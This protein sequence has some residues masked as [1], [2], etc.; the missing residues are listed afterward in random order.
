[1]KKHHHFEEK[2][3]AT[4][5]QIY[6]AASGD[7]GWSA[8]LESVCEVLAAQAVD[9]SIFRAPAVADAPA[10]AAGSAQSGFMDCGAA[11]MLAGLGRPLALFAHSGGAEHFRSS[12]SDGIPV[13]VS[14]A[15]P[16]TTGAVHCQRAWVRR[17][18][19]GSP[20]MV[21]TVCF[22]HQDEVA[23]ELS[24]QRL[25][26]LLPH[27]RRAFSVEQR[28]SHALHSEAEL[29][30]TLDHVC[31]AVVL[32]NSDAQ[33]LYANELALSLLAQADGICRASDQLLRLPD[34]ASQE[35][36]QQVLGHCGQTC[37]HARGAR[38]ALQ[39][40]V[41]GQAGPYV[42]TVQPLSRT[43]RLRSD[44][45]AVLLIQVPQTAEIQHLQPMRDTYGLTT[46]ELQLVHGLVNGRSLKQIAASK[47]ASYETMRV[48]LRQVFGKTGVN[49]QAQLVNLA[50]SGYP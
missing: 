14:S 18:D 12:E 20:W 1:M 13:P 16:D 3:L 49:R 30:E 50:R 32:L 24:R 33:I 25:A 2:L 10:V 45:A 40:V 36:L 46:S 42:V 7:L 29:K 38:A 21:L 9:L 41:R 22:Q 48:H 11:A 35:A 34:R 43:Q 44:A 17:S 39:M 37:E 15:G 19:D 28:L 6:A 4:V 31:K 47:G 8:V 26:L 27:M 23:G 5:D